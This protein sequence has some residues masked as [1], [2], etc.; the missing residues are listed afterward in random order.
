MPSNS[1]LKLRVPAVEHDAHLRLPLRLLL[2]VLGNRREL[3]QGGLQVFRNVQPKLLPR[4]SQVKINAIFDNSPGNPANPD[5]AKN[6]RWGPQTSDEMMIGY[7]EYY[8]PNNGD[9]AME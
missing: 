4:G 8:T 2:Q 1:S 9:V 3:L 5:P 6:V 7:I